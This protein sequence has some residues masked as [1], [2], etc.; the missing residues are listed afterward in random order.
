MQV[1]PAKISTH[2]TLFN[3][4]GGGADEGGV[5]VF[6]MREGGEITLGN[7]LND[8]GFEGGIDEGHATALETGTG[9]TT[10]IDAFGLGHNLIEANLLGGTGLPVMDAAP[11]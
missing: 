7:G 2:P 8:G 5:F 9:E 3:T 11:T 4:V 6:E 10:S 1:S